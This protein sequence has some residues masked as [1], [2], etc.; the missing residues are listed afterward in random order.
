MVENAE[1]R[2]RQVI[3]LEHRAGKILRLTNLNKQPPGHGKQ[4]R[5]FRLRTDAKRICGRSLAVDGPI[6]GG[7]WPG[8][9]FNLPVSHRMCTSTSRATSSE[10][11][12]NAGPGGVARRECCGQILELTRWPGTLPMRATYPHSQKCQ[13]VMQNNHPSRTHSRA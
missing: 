8:P 3:I 1:R 5:R 4:L 6:D 7:T 9:L 13:V 11:L 10:T 12:S 2:W